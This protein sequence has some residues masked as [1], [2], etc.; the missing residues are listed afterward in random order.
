[1]SKKEMSIGERYQYL[2]VMKKRYK[3]AN[4]PGKTELLDEAMEVTRYSRKHLIHL[5]NGGL[6]RKKRKGGRGREYGADV[7]D[8]LR[9]IYEAWDHICAERLT[10][11]LV[12]M[13]EHLAAHGEMVV[14]EGLLGQLGRISVST[15]ERRLRK[16]RQDEPTLPRRPPRREKA[17]LRGIPMGRLAW[18]TPEPGYMEADLVHHCGSSTRDVY[19]ITLQ[20]IDVKTGWSERRALL[21]RGRAVMTDA[22]AAVLSRLPFEVHVI[23]PDNDSAFFNAHLL[24]FWQER[25][26]GVRLTRSRPYQK[27]DNPRVEQKNRTLV[28][29]VLG[30]ARMDTVAH[31][32]ATNHLY[33]LMWVYYNLFQPVMHLSEKRVI[34]QDG[35]PVSVARRHDTAR[36]P[37]DRLCATDAILPQH[38]QRLEDLRAQTNPCQLR[39]EIWQAVAEIAALPGAVEGEPEDVY[40]TLSHSLVFENLVDDP[41]DLGFH[42]TAIQKRGR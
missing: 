35:Q 33:D 14:D 19:M 37:F 32:A 20:L 5:L 27:N 28:R 11:N 15:V 18:D 30:D 34:Y 6:E 23:H 2:R 7:D 21:G 9:V 4:R 22:F 25:V 41:L 39:R 16:L 42:R 10:P 3:K 1:M 8:A 12:W 13:A 17:V 31:V 29:D 36:T 26:P 38:R 40:E 24:H